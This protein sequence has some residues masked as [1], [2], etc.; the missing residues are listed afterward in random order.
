[1]NHFIR[2]IFF[3]SSPFLKTRVSI[4]ILKSW[5]FLF[6]PLPHTWEKGTL[7]IALMHFGEIFTALKLMEFLKEW[8]CFLEM[9]FLPLELQEKFYLTK[10][11]FSQNVSQFWE[12]SVFHE[13]N[14]NFLKNYNPPIAHLLYLLI[15]SDSTPSLKTTY[16]FKSRICSC[17]L[18]PE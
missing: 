4:Y 11:I 9:L 12:Y 10:D 14:K 5:G 3:T 18:K 7:T 13:I 1:M 6:S 15:L 2:H 8:L 17:E 16:S